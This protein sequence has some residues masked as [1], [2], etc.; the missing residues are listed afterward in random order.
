MELG[1]EN[2]VEV[3]AKVRV[4]VKRKETNAC[5]WTPVLA[6]VV[7]STWRSVHVTLGW[8]RRGVKRFQRCD[9]GRFRTTEGGKIINGSVPNP[10][11]SHKAR[12][13]RWH[14]LLVWS[15]TSGSQTDIPPS[16]RRGSHL[17][18]VTGL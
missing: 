18:A 15:F 17:V 13:Q 1:E 7:T 11:S 3:E 5:R 2:E 8:R 6:G 9:T 16:P 10:T 4:G 12:L 14:R